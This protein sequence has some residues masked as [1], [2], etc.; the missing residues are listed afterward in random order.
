VPVR[1]P[2]LLHKLHPFHPF[3][4]HSL[5]N[6]ITAIH[7]HLTFP[8]QFSPFSKATISMQV[9]RLHS[10]S[11]SRR[12]LEWG[13]SSSGFKAR[14]S[15]FG[16]KH[17]RCRPVLLTPAPVVVVRA[18]RTAAAA[19]AG[20]L[21]KSCACTRSRRCSQTSDIRT[22][23]LAPHPQQT[24]ACDRTCCAVKA[25]D[26]GKQLRGEERALPLLRIDTAAS[27]ASSSSF[28]RRHLRRHPRGVHEGPWACGRNGIHRR[29][30]RGGNGN[31]RR[32]CIRQSAAS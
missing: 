6:S 13:S 2:H 10:S 20:G 24:A 15:I 32:R 8:S 28:H 7:P 9:Q 3:N 16:W 19:E 14:R 21:G 27:W 18:V 12:D 25:N 5:S 11:T 26:G 1:S 29:L 22:Y 30:R 31:A 23:S 17:H 4:S